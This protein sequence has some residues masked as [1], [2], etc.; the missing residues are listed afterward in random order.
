MTIME[1][2]ALEGVTLAMWGF[3]MWLQASHVR[4]AV[5][6]ANTWRELYQAERSHHERMFDTLTSIMRGEP[7]DKKAS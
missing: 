5:K 2:M 6:D 1:V 3:T 7:E 4:L